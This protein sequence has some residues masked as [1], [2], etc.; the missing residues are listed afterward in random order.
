[1]VSNSSEENASSDERNKKII[2]WFARSKRQGLPLT[3]SM[4]DRALEYI[5]ENNERVV[6]LG[7]GFKPQPN[8]VEGEIWKK[9]YP[10]GKTPYKTASH[11]CDILV[12]AGILEYEYTRNPLTD[13]KVQGVK[14]VKSTP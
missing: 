13:R 6:R 4:F 11:I 5:N 10:I 3:F 7:T 12:L 8:T 1:M 9:P 2:I 14:I